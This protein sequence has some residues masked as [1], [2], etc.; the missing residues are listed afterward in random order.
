MDKCNDFAKKHIQKLLDG[1]DVSP[2][3]YINDIA[4]IFNTTIF[5]ATQR[6]GISNSF[7]WILFH[8]AHNDG[9]TQLQLVK[10]T[11]FTAPSISV[12]L[13]KMETDGFVKRVADE[14]DM[15]QVRVFLTDKGREHN[16]FI[17]NQCRETEVIMLNGISEKE[18]QKLCDLLRRILKN[19]VG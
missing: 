15:R 13:S 5:H 10:L 9:L 16:N 17:S 1:E 8:L 18:K 12:A 11:H 3:M 7:R 14:K 6:K 19:L 4:K 2:S